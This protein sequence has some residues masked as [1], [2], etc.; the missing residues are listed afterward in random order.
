M[1][2]KLGNNAPQILG[3]DRRNDQFAPYHG[4]VKILGN[5]NCFGNGNPREEIRIGVGGAHLLGLGCRVTPEGYIV[6]MFGEQN[7]E[8]GPPPTC[9]KDRNTH[10]LQ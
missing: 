7:G 2:A 4:L 6:M 3:R 9:T 1:V 5:A 8:R 10:G